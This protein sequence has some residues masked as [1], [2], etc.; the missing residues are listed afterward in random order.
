MQA[1]KARKNKFVNSQDDRH[2]SPGQP[3]WYLLQCRSRQDFRAAEHL[4]NQ[5][6]TCYQPVVQAERLQRGK[7]CQR[8]EPLFPGYLFIQL[9]S[10]NDNWGPIRSTRGVAR[11]VGFNGQPHPVPANVVKALQVRVAEAP[12]IAPLQPGDK[13]IIK[14]GAFADIEAIFQSFDGDE[15]VV[16]LLTLMQRPQQLVLPV[17]RIERQEP[18]YASA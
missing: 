2:T 11:M 9:D 15:R 8:S 1:G 6:Y 3:A 14:D 4:A 12:C 18:A 16:I 17:S 7:R 5:G 13:V 10:V